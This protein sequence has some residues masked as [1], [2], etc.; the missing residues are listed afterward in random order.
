MKISGH[1]PKVVFVNPPL[2]PTQRY[3]LLSPAGS[4][5][6]P[7]G[8]AYLAAVTRKM[9]LETAILDTLALGIDL[10]E[11]LR[12]IVD[13]RP[14]F[15]AIT[16]TTMSVR[17][18]S[19]L[20]FV[21]KEKIPG[22]KIIVGGCHLTSLPQKTL[23]E[24]PC[25]DIG[26]IGEG[27]ETLEELL[28]LLIN[29]G[30]LSSVEGI[31]FRHND[32][33]MLTSPRERI[34]N[35]DGLPL[36]AFDILPELKQYYRPATQSIKYLPTTSL[37]TSRGCTGHC[38]FCD[39][40]T[41]GN[42]FRMHSA[43]YIVDMI[44]KL[45]KDFS[46]KGIIFEDDNFFLSQRRLLNLA[47]LLK[48][49]RIRIAWSAMS[50][51]DTINEEKIRIAKSCGC[52][53]ILYGIE[54][55]S[56][57]ILDFYKKRISL[58]QIEKIIRLTKRCGIYTKGFFM[59]GN[60]LESHPTLEE[61]R[62][63]IRRL[64]FDDISVTYFTPY[65]GT[66]T[67]NEIDRFGECE[68]DWDRFTCYEVVFVP[69]G[70]KR[71]EI[72]ASQASILGEF[73]SRPGVLWSYLKRLRSFFQVRELYRSW[74]SLSRHLTLQKRTKKIVINSDDFGLCEGINRGVLKALQH[75]V[76]KSVSIM[77]SGF[78]FDS[79]VEIIRQNR[80][81]EVGVHLSL[82]EAVPVLSM[83][84]I[85]S[86]VNKSGYFV[87]SFFIFF[88]RYIFGKIKG[89][90]IY[91][92]LCAQ[93]ERVK[94]AGFEINHLDSHQHIHLMPGIFRIVLRLAKEY[95]IP[96]I[97]LPSIPIDNRY[98]FGKAKV[99]RKF[100]QL[101]LNFLCLIYRPILKLNGLRFSRHCFGF[102]E[103]GN[104][105]E[106]ELRGILSSLKEGRYELICHLGEEDDSLRHLIGH[107]GYHWQQE[108]EVLT[109]D[110]IKEY[111]YHNGWN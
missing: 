1:K 94:E 75:G 83:D 31:A 100:Y 41:F 98:L 110:S 29:G 11:S 12:L 45:R 19:Q 53:Q 13:E 51:V 104:L 64:P 65:P 74:R 109:S 92:E 35:L 39:R 71:Q 22:V 69:K 5:E 37:V 55:G 106:V 9:G 66:E 76:L 73:Y 3:G 32:H 58:S 21:V 60:P 70:L 111:I 38:L 93:V 10:K 90:H 68:K 18:A 44:E 47:Q 42:E 26:V 81:V 15:L 14:D 105:N 88:I 46:I 33:V 67:W 54:T 59:L 77:P 103:S 89:E 4:V 96:F 79:A 8:L 40:K 28:K 20:A 61:T 25:F 85:S 99:G 82:I 43:E 102:L 91:R 87:N 63:L 48:K 49:R 23:L 97:R 24:N 101:I 95:K 7:L 108:L 30:S 107:W 6:P 72:T 84:R 27:E 50:R 56:Q 16:S 62:G 86:L 80:A 17:S 78:A 36:P 57:R 2:S 52:W 34:K